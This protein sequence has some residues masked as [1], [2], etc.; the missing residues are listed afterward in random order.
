MGMSITGGMSMSGGLQVLSSGGSGGSDPYFANV[1][2]LVHG[3]GVNGGTTFTDSSS[4]NR[5]PLSI[6][7][8]VTSNEQTIFGQNTIKSINERPDSGGSI[9]E[10]NSSTDFA[11][12][13]AF[14]VEFQVYF[15]SGGGFLM[16]RS[17]GSSCNRD[18]FGYINFNGYPATVAAST[19]VTPLDSWNYIAY[20]YSPNTASLYVNGTRV[21]TSNASTEPGGYPFSLVGIPGSAFNPSF[22]GYIAEIRYTKGVAR[23]SGA[24]IPVQTS[25]WPNS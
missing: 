11:M 14:T 13:E 3:D 19:Q 2:L 7:N 8:V 15:T 4:K 20:S 22:G 21:A 9:L 17:P 1:V 25:P 24:T 12:D 6:Q 23:Y 10:Y 18:V 16:S 5:T